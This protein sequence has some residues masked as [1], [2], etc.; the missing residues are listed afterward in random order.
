MLKIGDFSRLSRVSVKALRFYAD[1]GLLP[2]AHIDAFTGYRY[3]TADQLPRLNRI[4]ALKDLGFTLEQIASALT[5]DL[6][7]EQ[8]RG[9]LRLKQA[10]IEQRMQA[11]QDLLARVEARLQQIEQEGKMSPYEVVIKKTDPIRVVSLRETVPSYAAIGGLF[12]PLY[13]YLQQHGVPPAGP[14]GAIWHDPGHK[15][16]DVDG[17]AYIPI[18]GSLTG[19]DRIQ[20]TTLPAVE[21]MASVI[22]H[23]SYN[24][25]SEAY[26]AILT[27]IEANGYTIT[28]PN[29]EIYLQCDADVKQDDESY[30]SE[31]QF[32]V[33]KA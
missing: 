20:V 23:G 17:E 8:L 16:S 14:C 31:I 18:E 11:D 22:H 33:Q 7:A 15:E 12:G 10:E 1:L 6:P 26:Q 29:R 21:T 24:R 28:G 32:P 19:N 9:M 5:E 13:G 30:V 27:W 2:A 4:L 25:F 3:Y